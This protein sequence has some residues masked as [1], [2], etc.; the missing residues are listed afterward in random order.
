VVSVIAVCL[1]AAAFVVQASAEDPANPFFGS[2]WERT[3]QPVAAGQVSRTW[4]WGPDAFTG[5]LSEP[6]AE[7]PGGQRA[8]QYFDKARMEITNPNGDS[9]SI[10]Y[11][12]NGLLVVELVTGRM[13]VGDAGFSQREPAAVNVAGDADDPTGPTYAT[14]GGLLTAGPAA[15][16][17]T[18]TNRLSRSGQVSADPGLAS[19]GLTVALIDEVTNHAIAAPFWSFMTSSGTV[20]NGSSYVVAP[21]FENAYFATGRPIAEAYWAN[22]KVGGIYQDVLMQCFERRCLTYNP[23]NDPNWRVEAGNVGRH[24]YQWRYVDSVEPPVEPPAVDYSY[25]GQFGLP[26]DPARRMREP[27]DVAF[28]S[29][30]NLYVVDTVN[31]RIQKYDANGLFLTQ[32]GERGSG[33]G[34]FDGPYSVAVDAAGNVYV[35][36]YGNDRIQKFD[37]N[38]QYLFQWGAEGSNLGQLNGPTGIAI[39]A[40]GNVYV[41][42]LLNYRVQKFDGM[43]TFLDVLGTGTSGNADGQ[44]GSA[45]GIAIDAAGSVY[46]CDTANH[47]IQVFDANGNFRRNWGSQGTENGAFDYPAGITL[48]PDQTR[49][50]VSDTGNDRVQ[51]FDTTGAF[52][53]TWGVRGS[54]L[55]E[56]DVPGGLAFSESEMLYIADELNNR[57]QIFDVSDGSAIGQITGDSRGRFSYPVGIEIIGQGD[58]AVVDATLNQVKLFTSDGDYLDEWGG[59]ELAVPLD[60]AVDSQ[61][62]LYVTDTDHHRVVKYNLQGQVVGNWGMN[63]AGN[64]QFQ[65]PA[66]I[67]VDAQDNVYVIDQ[68]NHRIQK[69]TSEGVF[70]TAWGGM[71]NGPGQFN[72]PWGIEVRGGSVYVTEGAN[73]RVQEFDLSGEFIRQWGSFGSGEAQF[74]VPYGIV[75]DEQGYLYVVDAG[76]DRV[77]KFTPTGQ[78]LAQ[79]G[80]TGSGDGQM[81]NPL[82]IAVGSNGAVYVA[83]RGNNRVM[84]FSA[85]R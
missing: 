53:T 59:T 43:G 31:D 74:N 14:F 27:L 26:S 11:V 80:M 47:R 1:L 68:K 9:A 85:T 54:D 49:I 38:G 51:V 37:K 24:Y 8:V 7:S 83:D 61:G 71:G 3:D 2:V 28:D 35:A 17:T 42:E 4:M 33:N 6:Y 66:G 81:E 41:T 78:F 64:G 73:H 44:F 69:F 84:I 52:L 70:L 12:T 58:L 10:W 57:I 55:G 34:Q 75:A 76:N 18:L 48:S 56:L 36:D 82:G 65:I 32:W 5:E 20:W 23:A 79:F 63:G 16:G 29:S 50:Y 60:V 45:Q 13:Q 22:V 19:H 77:Q 72:D 46:V 15:I 21:L 39:D 40:D 30:G 62:M 25:A 67:A